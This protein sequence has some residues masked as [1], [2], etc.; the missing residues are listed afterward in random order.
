MGLILTKHFIW[1]NLLKSPS[2]ASINVIAC[3]LLERKM[4]ESELNW[5]LK[6]KERK[7]KSPE[8]LKMLFKADQSKQRKTNKHLSISFSL[9][10]SG[11]II[12]EV[13]SGLWRWHDGTSGRLKL[14]DHGFNPKLSSDLSD[15]KTLKDGTWHKICLSCVCGA[16]KLA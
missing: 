13:C 14:G 3:L 1:A 6:A 2:Q 11:L 4:E 12:S 8:A 9:S 16:K 7:W 5:Q 15:V 10:P